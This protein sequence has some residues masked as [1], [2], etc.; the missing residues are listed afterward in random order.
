MN[1]IVIEGARIARDENALHVSQDDTYLFSAHVARGRYYNYYELRRGER[2][3]F[4][5]TSLERVVARGK[6]L[7]LD[8]LTGRVK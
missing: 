5:S 6:E 4:W 3:I 2:L 7:A 1:D 8:V